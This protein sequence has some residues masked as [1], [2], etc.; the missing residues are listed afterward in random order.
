MNSNIT[1][2]L[3]GNKTQPKRIA[4]LDFQ[5]GLAIWFMTL[6]HTFEHL[7]DYTW[8]KEEP[9]KI[10]ELPLIVLIF[11]LTLG[12]FLSWNAYFLLISSIVTTISMFRKMPD[13]DKQHQLLVKQLLTGTGILLAGLLADN[14]GY[15][16]YFGQSTLS[17]DWTNL[18]PLY[19]RIFAMHTLQII[20]WCLIIN[21]TVNFFLLRRNGHEKY[22]RNIIVYGV[23]VVAIITASPFIHNFVDSLPWKIPENPPPGITDNTRWPS[24]YF[25]A[26]NASLKA[27]ICAI[28]AGDMEPLFPYLAT[29]FMGSMIGL[30]ISRHKQ[31][32]RFP[33][34]AG[35]S[36]IGIMGIGGI[37]I[38]FGQY[39]LSNGR[40]TLGNY[41]A[42]IGGQI[43][44]IMLLFWAVEYRGNSERF[45]NNPIV[46]HFRLWGMASLT[47][48]CLQIFEILPRWILTVMLS[49][50]GKP[51]NL[52]Q[53]AVFGLGKE[54]LALLVGLFSILYFEAL[55][56]IWSRFNFK[57]SF[58][59]FIVKMTTSGSKLST[60]RLN[61][62]M[63]MNKVHWMS[64]KNPNT[65]K[66]IS[67]RVMRAVKLKRK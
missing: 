65:S 45:A 67:K 3:T 36:G 29:S 47:I 8:V 13:L 22:F 51:I 7:Y 42:I 24:V 32:K 53:E 66:F 10:L 16:G 61:V 18:R 11:G 48:Y 31:V 4:S 40:P 28:L 43:A 26:E 30:T 20:G 19:E 12:F 35:L 52:L 5:R 34:I 14:L 56:S 1:K 62:D 54:Y 59:W 57:Y 17:G 21:G 38:A 2:V 58:E 23:L 39:N 37:F 49:V 9:E 55:I 25:Q 60:N 33:L 46:K 50:F 64:F 41:L 15:W 63:I 6:M 27:W 44:V